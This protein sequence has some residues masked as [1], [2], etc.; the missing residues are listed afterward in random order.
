MSVLIFAITEV[1]IFHLDLF[2]QVEDF[3]WKYTE[4]SEC[5]FCVILF[6]CKK[7]KKLQSCKIS[8]TRKYC[9]RKRAQYKYFLWSR[10]FV[11]TSVS[12]NWN[13]EV[14]VKTLHHEDLPTPPTLKQMNL[15]HWE[16]QPP[17]HWWPCRNPST[18]TPSSF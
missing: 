3:K 17:Q 13:F 1:W 11:R 6:I 9:V 2:L 8:Y 7:P 10:R 12:R 4:K 5:I 15:S 16:D 18:W 14:C